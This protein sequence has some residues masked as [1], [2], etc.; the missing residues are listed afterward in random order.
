MP[1]CAVFQTLTVG[2]Q[3]TTALVLQPAR[4]DQ[5]PATC[6]GYILLT[7]EEFS[8]LQEPFFLPLTIPQAATI[9]TAILALW[10]L[11]F[12]WRQLGGFLSP[13]SSED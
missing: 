3:V 4:A 2:K 9:A 7:P 8:S 10:S 1:Q 12:V 11:A 5:T 6:T 13:S